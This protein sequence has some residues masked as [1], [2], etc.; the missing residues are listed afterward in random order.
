MQLRGEQGREQAPHTIEADPHLHA[1]GTQCRADPW[2]EAI[3]ASTGT[4]GSQQAN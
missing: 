1:L 4:Q 3:A 2:K